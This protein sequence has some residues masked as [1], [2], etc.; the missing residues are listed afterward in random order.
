MPRRQVELHLPSRVERIARVFTGNELASLLKK[1]HLTAGPSQPRSCD[2]P[3]I[4][5]PDHDHL[6]VVVELV[7]SR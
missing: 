5:G 2:P 6:V 1:A 7:D 4:A 3:A